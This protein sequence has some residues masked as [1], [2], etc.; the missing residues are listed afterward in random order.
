[1]L[2]L[3]QS[4]SAE[5]LPVSDIV[6]QVNSCQVCRSGSEEP[7]VEKHHQ[8]GK[9]GNRQGPN[10]GRHT[11]LSSSAVL[12]G[13]IVDANLGLN[14]P[15]EAT[16]AAKLRL[17]GRRMGRPAPIGLPLPSLL[18]DAHLTDIHVA[19]ARASMGEDSRRR[20]RSEPTGDRSPSYTAASAVRPC[21]VNPAEVMAPP[22]SCLIKCALVALHWWV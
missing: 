14:G 5:L 13:R 9:T 7:V 16:V 2:L 4:I 6:A 8:R 19:P 18:K 10:G 20:R 1:M 12:P 22:I 15:C 21:D 11:P 17:I 3:F